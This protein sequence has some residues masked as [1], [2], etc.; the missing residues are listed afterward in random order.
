M[1][2]AILRVMVHTCMSHDTHMNESWHTCEWVMTHTGMGD[3][4]RSLISHNCGWCHPQLGKKKRFFGKGK[5][6]EKTVSFPFCPTADGTCTWFIHEYT[7]TTPKISAIVYLRLCVHT[8][9]CIYMSLVICIY[10]CLIS[11]KD[12]YMNTHSYKYRFWC[13]NLCFKNRYCDIKT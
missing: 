11:A 1:A 12:L 4:I 6:K 8:Y 9:T 3:A 5:G 7:I 13:E 10:I 2:S